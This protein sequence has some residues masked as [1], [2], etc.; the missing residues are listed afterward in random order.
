MANPK[1]QEV[2][3]FRWML[4]AIEAGDCETADREVLDSTWVRQAP[5]RAQRTSSVVQYGK[6]ADE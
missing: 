2:Y 6:L 5:T 3:G 1:K 4:A